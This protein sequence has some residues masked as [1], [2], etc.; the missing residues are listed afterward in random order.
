MI[1]YSV[2]IALAIGAALG[3]LVGW[4]AGRGYERLRPGRRSKKR[5]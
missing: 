4:K 2:L 3:G 1:F 5:R